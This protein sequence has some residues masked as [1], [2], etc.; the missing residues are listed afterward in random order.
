MPD[1]ERIVKAKMKTAVQKVEAEFSKYPLRKFA[2]KQI[3]VF[4]GE[5]PGQIFYLVKGKVRQYDVSPRGDEIVIN[6]FKP[7]AYFPMSWAINKGE[8]P[9][10][11]EAETTVEARL[12][13]AEDAVA[14]IKANPDVMYDLLSR[15]YSGMDGIL[16]RMVRLMSASAG[17]RVLYELVIES[18]RF[19]KPDKNGQVRLSIHENQ[20]AARAGLTRETVSREVNKLKNG[21]LVTVSGRGIVIKDIRLLEEKLAGEF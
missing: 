7:P 6:V 3:L 17:A 9:Y 21:G 10:F 4:G 14:F 2:K 11:F 5:P 1:G 18:R 20:L 15:L 19:G 8:N 12:V 13:P 16:G